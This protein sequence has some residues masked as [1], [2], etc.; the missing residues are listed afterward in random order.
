[1]CVNNDTVDSE[2]KSK[3]TIINILSEEIEKL[4]EENTKLKQNNSELLQKVD[5]LQNKYHVVQSRPNLKRQ[6]S[7]TVG[8]RPNPTVPPKISVHNKFSVLQDLDHGEDET[9]ENVNY[10]EKKKE[11]EV[12]VIGDSLLKFSGEVCKERGYEV[13]C[14]PGIKTEELRHKVEQLDLQ[15]QNPKVVA[16]H[17]GTNSVSK[18]VAAE[19]IMGDTLD[20]VDYIKTQIKDAKIVISG[21]LRRYDVSI[22]KTTRINSELDWL[23]QVRNCVMVDGNCWLKDNDFARDGVH[24]NR[25]GSHK[26][27]TLLCK[28]IESSKKGNM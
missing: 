28:A 13:M 8:S 17:V 22:R 9:E 11:A 20:L 23:C 15:K 14:F 27:G 16:I 24:L 21:L 1:M 12:L 25:R 5:Y 4:K 18:G 2:L 26:L 19:E 3:T 7:V 10:E 6:Y